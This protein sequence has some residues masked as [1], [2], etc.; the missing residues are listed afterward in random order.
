[1]KRRM[2]RHSKEVVFAVLGALLLLGTFVIKDVLLDTLKESV[3]IA[4]TTI[5]NFQ[6]Y[7]R[8]QGLV[9]QV[10]DAEIERYTETVNEEF[11]LRKCA[12]ADALN[13]VYQ[14]DKTESENLSATLSKTK[15]FRPERLDA[16]QKWMK[17]LDDDL[18][19][20]NSTV[21][22]LDKVT[23]QL[24]N[25]PSWDDM[26]H[27]ANQANHRQEVI[28]NA[29]ETINRAFIVQ[30]KIRNDLDKS[31]VILHLFEQDLEAKEWWVNFYTNCTWTLFGLGLSLA[32]IG[33][34]FRIPGTDSPAG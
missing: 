19:S 18:A 14:S 17:D 29:S 10:R 12:T 23:E 11:V 7:R 22:Y 33:K 1:M 30:K 8:Y 32:V 21:D 2:K 4:Q 31:G 15:L 26:L 27:P 5:S 13:S 9:D 24:I 20:S 28:E 3:G 16:L 25:L 6:Q 34:I